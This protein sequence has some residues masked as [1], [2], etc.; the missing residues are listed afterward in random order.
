MPAPTPSNR[1]DPTVAYLRVNGGGWIDT[2]PGVG[3]LVAEAMGVPERVVW[4][5][6]A[7]QLGPDR[8]AW[9]RQARSCGYCARPVRLTGRVIDSDGVVRIDTD[10]LPDRVLLKRCGN[11]RASVCPSCSFQY[12]GDMWHLLKAGM[13]GGAK[14][15]PETVASHPTV[16]VTLT[17]PGFGPVHTT[18]E[19][20]GRP[21]RCRPRREGRLCPHGRPPWCM[22]TH[23]E[24][25]PRLGHA[26]CPDCYDYIGAVAF[27]WHAPELWRRF[28][29]DLYRTIA[30]ARGMTEA[31]LRRHVRI[32]YAKVAEPQARG[33]VNFHAIIRLDHPT[34]EEWRPPALDIPTAALIDAVKAAASR[35]CDTVTVGTNDTLTL[36]FGSQVDVQSIRARSGLDGEELTP[37]KVAAYVAKYATKGCEDFG[38]G[39]R[40][41]DG[42]T[43]SCK[44]LPEHSQRMNDAALKLARQPGYERLPRWTHMHGFRVTSPPIA[45]ATRPPSPRSGKRE[46]IIAAV[47]RPVPTHPRG[48]MGPGQAATPMT[49]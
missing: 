30:Q 1:R 2:D 45:G 48:I 15:L 25:D 49:R 31:D 44:G 8:M 37:E 16:F 42:Y 13:S 36:R 23:D 18:R 6:L 17:A 22:T 29:I 39:S 7:R 20:N 35:T 38:L 3:R 14:G 26:L 24:R 34:N 5:I 46:P 12:R 9:E 10:T 19:R 43:A 32:S 4:Q 41:L 40:P 27:N 21:R 47:R 28:T 11:R 33:L